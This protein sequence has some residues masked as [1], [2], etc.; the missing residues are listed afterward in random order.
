MT[1]DVVV[2]VRSWPMRCRRWACVSRVCCV[3]P[4]GTS[5]LVCVFVE[6]KLVLE[7][8]FVYLLCFFFF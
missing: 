1:T 7:G 6:R 5:L 3:A 4:A 2:S 8:L